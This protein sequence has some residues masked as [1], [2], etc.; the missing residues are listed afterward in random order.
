[1]DKEFWPRTVYLSTLPQHKVC[2]SGYSFYCR[3][4]ETLVPKNMRSS[5]LYCVN[6]SCVQNRKNTEN[7]E[8]QEILWCKMVYITS[9]CKLHVILIHVLCLCLCSCMCACL[10]MCMDMFMFMCVYV[11]VYIY[12]YT[13]LCI[14]VCLCMFIFINININ[15]NTHTHKHKH[16]QKQTNINTHTHK[17][18]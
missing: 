9:R 18:A 3:G 6:V 11:Y 13:C 17:H 2:Q 10:C 1:M 15:I 5:H 12:V 16:T 4:F 14:C 7:R 8:K